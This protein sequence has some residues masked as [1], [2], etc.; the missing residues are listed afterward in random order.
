[1]DN[2]VCSFVKGLE[3]AR[4]E[5]YGG[6]KP[7]SDAIVLWATG[8][9]GIRRAKKGWQPVLALY[10]S[11]LCEIGRGLVKNRSTSSL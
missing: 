4:R 7:H 10:T 1:V 11:L 3:A 2:A 6:K 5:K 8:R 9:S